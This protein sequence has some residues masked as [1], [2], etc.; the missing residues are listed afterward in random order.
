MIHISGFKM[1][2]N[3]RWQFGNIFGERNLLSL[4]SFPNEF[5]EKLGESRKPDSDGPVSH[6]VLRGHVQTCR[7]NLWSNSLVPQIFETS[8][9]WASPF[10]P[11]GKTWPPT[12]FREEITTKKAP[13]K[14][15]MCIQKNNWKIHMEHHRTLK[16]MGFWSSTVTTV[17]CGR[18]SA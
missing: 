3:F 14:R 1:F 10:P 12:L 8:G 16:W 15:Y 9:G 7:M 11:L 4:L 18:F 13:K 5:H 2:P 17:P 6:A